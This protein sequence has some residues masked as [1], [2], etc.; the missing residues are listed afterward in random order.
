MGEQK[1]W[2][3]HYTSISRNKVWIQSA[4]EMESLCPQEKLCKVPLFQAKVIVP[5][6]GCTPGYLHPR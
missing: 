5:E 3:T 4:K 2:Y 1:Y 6:T